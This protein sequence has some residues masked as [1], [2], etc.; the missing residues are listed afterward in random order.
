[1]KKDE[2]LE[3]L[4]RIN[5]KVSEETQKDIRFTIRVVVNKKKEDL[6]KLISEKYGEFLMFQMAKQKEPV[7]KNI[8]EAL[9]YLQRLERQH[10]FQKEICLHKTVVSLEAMVRL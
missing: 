10:P 6:V 5:K 8:S 7:H 9:A 2:L 4:D 3:L 1:M